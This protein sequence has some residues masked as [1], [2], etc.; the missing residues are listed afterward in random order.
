MCSFWENP[1]KIH[2]FWEFF[3]GKNHL[4]LE[5]QPLQLSKVLKKY[6]FTI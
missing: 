1:P 2:I 5:I 3:G 6:N 4:I